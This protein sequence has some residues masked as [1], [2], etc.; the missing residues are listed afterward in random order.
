ML[1]KLINNADENDPII[2][3][4]SHKQ[5]IPLY[6]NSLPIHR[7]V[8]DKANMEMYELYMKIK[9]TNPYAEFVG[10]KTD[11]LVFKNITNTPPTS[12]KWGDI[13]ISNV[14]LIKECTINQEP[15][16]RTEQFKLLNNEWNNIKWMD[17]EYYENHKKYKMDKNLETY[18]KDG[19]L[20][21]GMAG[22]G[23]S[24]I[25]SESQYILEKITHSKYL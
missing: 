11:C 21:I 15:K 12:D 20:F 16:L 24:E 6:E 7:K 18:I 25:L 5:N 13:K 10:I 14:P 23:K 17:N 8:Y 19:I 22:T 1:N 2:Y 9:D 3:R 4:L